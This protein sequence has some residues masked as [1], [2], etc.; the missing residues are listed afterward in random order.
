MVLHNYFWGELLGTMTLTLFGCGAVA[1]SLLKK[2]K[3]ESGGWICITTGWALAVV[4]GVF[5]A[6]AAGS[7]QADI[8]P[9]VTLAKYFLH[10][11]ISHLQVMEQIAAQVVGAFFGAVLVWL[12]YLPHWKATTDERFKLMVFATSPE[13]KCFASNVICEMI[14]AFA[15]VVVI[16]ALSSNSSVPAGI[17]P[18][19]VGLLVW[20]I[21]LSLGGPTGYAINPARDLGPRIAHAILPLGGKGSSEWSYALVPIIGPIIGGVIGAIVWVSVFAKF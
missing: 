10:V 3:G 12:A 13:I 2:S 17:A 21:G 7:A 5:V 4:F 6:Q 8:N 14:G 19:F 16:G 11:Y 15:L 1:N 20:A 18:Y 9:A